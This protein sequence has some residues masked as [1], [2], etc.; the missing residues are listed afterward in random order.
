MKLS[1]L[2]PAIVESDAERFLTM[3][4]PH[5]RTHR[6]AIQIIGKAKMM[7]GK[8]DYDKQTL[9]PDEPLRSCGLPFGVR[10]GTVTA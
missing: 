7:T 8:D 2:N 6:I 1:G 4:C 3:D 9:T 5:C 10:R